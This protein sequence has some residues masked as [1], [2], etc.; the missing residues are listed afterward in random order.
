MKTMQFCYGVI[1]SSL[2]VPFAGGCAQ[3]KSFVQRL[4]GQQA[5]EPKM[6]LNFAR[7]QEKEG[8]LSKA[9]ESYRQLAREN[10]KD[11][12][13]K[14]RLG[15]VLVR[16]GK[17]DEGVALLEEA[18]QQDPRNIALLNDLGYAYMTEGKLEQAD[19]LFHEALAIDSKNPRS[20]NNLAICTGYSGRL[21]EAYAL[22]RQSMSEAEANANMG[23]VHA[24][25]GE[26]DEA[27]SWYNRALTKDPGMKPAAEAMVQLASIRETLQ[28]R[29]EAIAANQGAGDSQVELAE[30][31]ESEPLAEAPI[32]LASGSSEADSPAPAAE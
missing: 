7:V 24:Q 32:G 12:E 23:F 15:V 6:R 17:S 22:F 19:R 9:E 20:I 21:D 1:V 16:K 5:D 29:R 4:S 14:H 26:I 8:N 10:P 30:T 3:S 31:R 18:R 13:L 11:P 25:M 2:L 28:T 27:M